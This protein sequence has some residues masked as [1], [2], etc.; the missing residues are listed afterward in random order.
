ML[1]EGLELADV[2][3]AAQSAQQEDHEK[4]YRE[5]KYFDDRTL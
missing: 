5:S 2:Q 3:S 4:L 1:L